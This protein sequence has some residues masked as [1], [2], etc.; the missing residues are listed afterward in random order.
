MKDID[1]KW[2]N[3]QQELVLLL[4]GAMWGLRSIKWRTAHHSSIHR[5]RR[6]WR[7]RTDVLR[8]H[9]VA[10]LRHSVHHRTCWRALP[11]WSSVGHGRRDS[12]R[13]GWRCER[14]HD[15]ILRGAHL[16][17]ELRREGEGGRGCG[18]SAWQLLVAF[19]DDVRRARTINQLPEILWNLWTWQLHEKNKITPNLLQKT[20]NY[21]L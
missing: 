18:H 10:L 9:D 6:V 21:K 5:L 17:R 8:T 19:Y 12:M 11:L 2:S 16:R 1:R 14:R 3:L 13:S 20:R 7:V 4:R 15:L